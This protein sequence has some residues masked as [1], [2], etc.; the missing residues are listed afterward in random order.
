LILT[1]LA[2]VAIAEAIDP[3]A[4]NLAFT[5]SAYACSI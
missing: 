1:L 5:N 3:V 4:E 2:A